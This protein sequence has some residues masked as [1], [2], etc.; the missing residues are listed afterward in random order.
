MQSSNLH[1]FN[2]YN[3]LTNKK[4]LAIVIDASITF[5]FDPKFHILN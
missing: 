4:S 2:K 5:N 1:S 3:I